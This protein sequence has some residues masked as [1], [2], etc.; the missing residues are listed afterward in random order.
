MPKAEYLRHNV[1]HDE[2]ET[3]PKDLSAFTDLEFPGFLRDMQ[4]FLGS[5]N[6]YS[7]FIENHA[8]YASVLYQLREIAY[9]TMEKGVWIPGGS[10]LTD[11]SRW[12]DKLWWLYM[13]VIGQ[14]P[15]QLMQEYAQT[16]YPVMF[17]SPTLKSTELNYGIA[18]K[19]VLALLRIL[20]LNYNTLFGRPTRIQC[21]TRSPGTVGRATFT[22]D[23]RDRQ[24]C[25]GEDKILDILDASIT[26]RSELDEALISIAPKKEPRRKIE[27]PTPTV[28]PD[29]DLYVASFDG[30]VRVKRVVKDRSGFVEGLTVNDAKYH[31][32]L[33]CLDLLEGTD[34][35][36]LVIRGYSN[37][38]I[39]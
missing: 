27:A 11:R 28:R 3:N 14:S 19:E 35:L 38:G 4:T 8:L 1:S 7:R 21:I 24:V 26:P 17:A 23:P 20:D 5:L 34:P 15:V 10:M 36:R 33:L 18:E 32:L 29:E 2:L 30:S 6:Y 16:Y 37:L 12:I 25:K 22:L 13:P 39:R 9:A 31:D